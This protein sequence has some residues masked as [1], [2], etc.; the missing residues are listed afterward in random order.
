MKGEI[1]LK[2]I[3]VSQCRVY[4]IN[5]GDVKLR[6]ISEKSSMDENQ[7]LE[8]TVNHTDT[9]NNPI[10]NKLQTNVELITT[11]IKY[12]TRKKFSYVNMYQCYS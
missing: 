10:V 3:N 1:L 12:K 8:F 7:V 4:V 9:E 2:Q 6:G 5:S 11:R